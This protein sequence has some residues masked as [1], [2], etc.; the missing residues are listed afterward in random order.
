MI[1]LIN[2]LFKN[3]LIVLIPDLFAMSAKFFAG[4]MPNIFKKPKSLNG[5]R[6][7][8]SLL[9]ISIICEDLF[10]FNS[11]IYNFSASR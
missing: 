5:L 3:P 8:P 2:S 10:K 4:S 11:F 7:I 9:P 6:A 1:F